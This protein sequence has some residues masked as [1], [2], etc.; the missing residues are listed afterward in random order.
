[1]EY[2]VQGRW[3][4][5]RKWYERVLADGETSAGLDV[6]LCL[7]TGRGGPADAKRA[8]GLVVA[9]TRLRPPIGV[10]LCEHEEAT[11]LLGVLTAR[12]IGTRKSIAR[13]RR[14]LA[15]A[16]IDGDYP[17]AARAVKNLE[18]VNP[19]DVVRFPPWRPRTRPARKTTTS[20]RKRV[21]KMLT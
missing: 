16:N 13:A 8:Y 14:L 10:S 4:L 17:E 3:P 6:A 1:M 18:T 12:G 5:A 2:A 15:K 20:D 11:A 7:L 9:V 21:G 19:L